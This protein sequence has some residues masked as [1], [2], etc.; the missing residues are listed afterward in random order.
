MIIQYIKNILVGLDQ[1]INALMLGDPDETMSSR[2]GR[3][4][5][6]SAWRKFIDKL[7]FWQSNHCHKAI[8]KNEGKKDLLFP[9]VIIIFIICF[10]F[11][12]CVQFPE[13]KDFS[14]DACYQYSVCMYYVAKGKL[15][16]NCQLEYSACRK[17]TI[18][19][20]CKD[21]KKRWEKQGCQDCYNVRD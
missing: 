14:C 6:K 7:F 19:N 1:F 13:R 9:R 12:G 15:Q 17:D 18:Y 4:W 21:E 5:P 16:S 3:V 2:A 10:F 8:E 20:D 11:T